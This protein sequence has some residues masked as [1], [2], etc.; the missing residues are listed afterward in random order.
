MPKSSQKQ[1]ISLSELYQNG[2]FIEAEKLALQITK[3]FPMHQLSWK[4]LGA[5][6]GVNG[7]KFK[8]GNACQKAVELSPQDAEAHNLGNT[9][10]ELGRL[11]EAEASYKQAIAI[12]SDYAEAHYNLGNTLKELEN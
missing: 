1:L 7:K 9:L 8:A 11:D 4:F 5:V 10:Q 3:N 2:K 12:R 6:L